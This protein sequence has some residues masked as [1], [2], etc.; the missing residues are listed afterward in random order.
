MPWA[1]ARGA[2]P[3]HT[4]Y[5]ETATK[6]EVKQKQRE[7]RNRET[8]PKLK[9][10]QD[11]DAHDAP[12][13]RIDLSPMPQNTAISRRTLLRSASATALAASGLAAAQNTS[14]GP[15]L[16]LI[17]YSSLLH[18]LQ[19]QGTT[20]GGLSGLD[21]DRQ[22]DVY[23]A[24]SDDRSTLNPARFYTLKLPLTADSLGAAQLQSVTTLQAP[25][26]KAYPD[27]RNTSADSA[28]VPDP[29]SIRLR[30]ATNTLY[31]TSEGD[32]ARGQ[33]PFIR[34]MRADG[35]YA[36][37]VPVPTMFSFDATGK[38][39]V[40][41][42]KGFEGLAFAPSGD[43][44]WVAM[45]AALL[46]DGPV[47]TVGAVGGPIRLT[48]F[49]IH[50]AQVFRQIAY[51]PDAIP[52]APQL[53]GISAPASLTPSALADN[54]VSEIWMASETG[55]LVLER[56][57][58]YGVGNSVRLYWIDTDDADDVLD[59]PSLVGAKFK[60][61][62]KVLLLDFAK[63]GVPRIDNIEGMT[64][65]PTLPNGNPTLVFVSDDNFSSSQTTQF[66]AFEWLAN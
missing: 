12:Q 44:L 2:D 13:H 32:A 18:K 56:A 22:K 52:A 61:A 8:V 49:A 43:T 20:V 53:A 36:S 51:I 11:A 30:S 10:K 62:S 63:A 6:V 9:A 31:W 65:G 25:N 47:P 19:F 40:R 34:E 57:W 27:K 17:G 42:N 66:I 39:G 21:Y 5:R 60:P 23:Y 16:R 54:G 7:T 26:G 3:W 50:S 58:A 15:R 29:E 37:Q 14:G 28:E 45:E 59:I 1:G 38:T 35:S 41:D 48:Q 55:M 33:A 24:I 64:R 46:Q 4:L